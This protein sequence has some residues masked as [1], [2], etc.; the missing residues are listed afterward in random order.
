MSEEVVCVFNLNSKNYIS[1][2]DMRKE[3]KNYG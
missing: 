2:S 1:E 3:E